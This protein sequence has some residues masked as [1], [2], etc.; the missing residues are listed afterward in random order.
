MFNIQNQ[1][2]SLMLRDVL[3]SETSTSLQSPFIDCFPGRVD[4]MRNLWSSSTS[5]SAACNC[6]EEAASRQV[7]LGETRTSFEEALFAKRSRGR[8]RAR[9]RARENVVVALLSRASLALLPVGERLEATCANK[10]RIRT[11]FVL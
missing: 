4:L 6:R 10:K 3:P 1:L 9:G 8:E 11:G 5:C 7:S 2:R